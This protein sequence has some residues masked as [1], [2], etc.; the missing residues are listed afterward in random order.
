MCV[1]VGHSL[2]N[3]I[4]FYIVALQA[5]GN[6]GITLGFV[7]VDLI[8]TPVVF[9]GKA[10]KIADAVINKLETRRSAITRPLDALGG[11]LATIQPGQRK[12]SS[13]S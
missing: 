12:I 3:Q 1:C 2:E 8:T 9:W 10:T 11:R 13:S 4:G 6:D 7:A 5:A